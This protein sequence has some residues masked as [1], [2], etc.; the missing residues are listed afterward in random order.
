MK[1]VTCMLALCFC[2]FALFFSAC[3]NPTQNHITSSDIPVIPEETMSNEQKFRYNILTTKSEL[4]EL[5]KKEIEEQSQLLQ[6][7]EIAEITAEIADKLAEYF[8][9]CQRLEKADDSASIV[10]ARHEIFQPESPNDHFTTEYWILTSSTGTE[11]W[12]M[13]YTHQSFRAD[14][15][16]RDTPDGEVLYGIIR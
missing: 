15:I 2:M 6:D 9:R 8:V 5:E 13:G 10:T 1:Q 11:Y 4:S 3:S 14:A 12:L 16:F 7:M